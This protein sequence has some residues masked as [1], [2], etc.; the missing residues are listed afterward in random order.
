M[1]HFAVPNFESIGDLLEL[2]AG[3]IPV[4]SEPNLQ[5]NVEEN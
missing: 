5:G 2:F 4:L 3:A 1:R